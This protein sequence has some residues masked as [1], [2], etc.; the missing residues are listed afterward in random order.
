ML[1]LN[2]YESYGNN[3]QQE[4]GNLNIINDDDKPLSVQ[5]ENNGRLWV[6]GFMD[7]KQRY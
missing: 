5:N 3:Q 6:K 4:S 1:F 7:A 2:A